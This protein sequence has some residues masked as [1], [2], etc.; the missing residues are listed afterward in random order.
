MTV[1]CGGIAMKRSNVRR[2][3]YSVFATTLIVLLFSAILIASPSS[4]FD[5]VDVRARV[6]R[7]VFFPMDFMAK[8]HG[9]PS[10]NHTDARVLFLFFRLFLNSLFWGNLIGCPIGFFLLPTRETQV[11]EKDQNNADRS[12]PPSDKAM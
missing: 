7:V 6:Q 9:Y 3:V 1:S 10:P 11:S 12:L 4:I 8:F 5:N 2:I